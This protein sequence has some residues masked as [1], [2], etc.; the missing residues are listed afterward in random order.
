MKGEIRGLKAGEYLSKDGSLLLRVSR[1]DDGVL[2]EIADFDADIF[3]AANVNDSKAKFEWGTVTPS[4]ID[5]KGDTNGE[6]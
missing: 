4:S 2:I 3:Y 6:G 1:K 5:D